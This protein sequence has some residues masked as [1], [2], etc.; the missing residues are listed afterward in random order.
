MT[1]L[2][3]GINPQ[4]ISMFVVSE[5]YRYDK[6]YHPLMDK[7]Y[8]KK[9]PILSLLYDPYGVGRAWGFFLKASVIVKG[10]D[11]SSLLRITCKSNKEAEELKVELEQELENFLG[12]AFA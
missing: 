1:R 5:G 3:Y 4:C 12:G 6:D 2:I 10:T 7:L 9:H 8:K 11:G